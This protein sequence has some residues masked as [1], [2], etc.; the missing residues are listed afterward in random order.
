MST[1]DAILPCTKPCTVER[2][3]S[4]ISWQPVRSNNKSTLEYLFSCNN[5]WQHVGEDGKPSQPVETMPVGFD[6]RRLQF[7]SMQYVFVFNR[8]SI[9]ACA[10]E[11]RPTWAAPAARVREV[12]SLVFA[13]PF[14]R[15][16]LTPRNDPEGNDSV[17]KLQRKL[18]KRVKPGE[19]VSLSGH[20][21]RG[22]R[23]LQPLLK[24]KGLA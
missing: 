1:S 24:S 18:N 23:S 10:R 9:K 3:N 2:V 8:I 21:D 12:C 15:R 6:S 17:M 19:G 7:L 20:L 11:N 16:S 4:G 22:P 5:L 13:V 14:R